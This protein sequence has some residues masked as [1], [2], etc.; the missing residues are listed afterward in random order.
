MDCYRRKH[1]DSGQGEGEERGLWE[2]TYDGELAEERTLP[3]RLRCGCLAPERYGGDDVE[4]EDVE[5]PVERGRYAGQ[6]DA[7]AKCVLRVIGRR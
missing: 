1:A 4:G 5:D 3:G 6:M 2:M 7:C